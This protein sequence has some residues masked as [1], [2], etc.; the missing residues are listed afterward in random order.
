MPVAMEGG[1]KGEGEANDL[2]STFILA[3][4]PFAA[5][6]VPRSFPGSARRPQGGIRKAAAAAAESRFVTRRRFF[7]SP[8]IFAFSPAAALAGEFFCSSGIC[9]EIWHACRLSAPLCLRLPPSVYLSICPFTE[10]FVLEIPARAPI[11]QCISRA[12][13][14]PSLPPSSREEGREEGVTEQNRGLHL[15]RMPCL[16]RT[17]P[18]IRT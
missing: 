7:V 15:F 9:H 1:G 4:P 5:A 14:P 17:F 2:L 8:S 6:T 18:S 13:L 3:V 11:I 12:R 10:A 16:P